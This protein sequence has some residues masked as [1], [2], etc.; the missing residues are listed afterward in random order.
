VLAPE[1]NISDT[2]PTLIDRKQAHTAQEEIQ[3]S[4]QS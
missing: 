2:W 1:V 3:K 4:M